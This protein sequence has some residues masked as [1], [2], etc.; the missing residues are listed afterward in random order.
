[1]FE[2]QYEILFTTIE[3]EQKKI[4]VSEWLNLLYRCILKDETLELKI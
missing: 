2:Y 1:M 4:L 3:K